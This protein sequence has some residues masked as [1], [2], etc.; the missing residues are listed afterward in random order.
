MGAGGG[1]G[2]D[3]GRSVDSIFPT[4]RDG[5]SGS[6]NHCSRSVDVRVPSIEQ[7][8]VETCGVWDD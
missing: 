3:K 4:V 1:S 7:P 8:T 6:S 2:G 5:T